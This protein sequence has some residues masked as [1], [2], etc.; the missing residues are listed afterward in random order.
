[1]Q[2]EA[3]D[4]IMTRLKNPRSLDPLKTAAI[5]GVNQTYEGLQGRMEQ[6]LAARGFNQSGKLPLNLRALE[7]GRLGDIGSLESKFAGMQ[8][9]QENRLIDEAMRYGFANPGHQGTQTMPGNM[10][11]GGISS[12]LETMTSLFMLSRLLSGGGGLPMSQLNE[13]G[14]NGWWDAVTAANNSVPL[15]GGGPR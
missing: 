4:T 10:L 3:Y 11:G 6:A 7:L 1:M 14:S 2:Q 13:P 15:P 8:I 9:D 5:S 12:G